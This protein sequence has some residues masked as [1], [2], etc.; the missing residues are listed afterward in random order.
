[1]QEHHPVAP[2]PQRLR[3]WQP[4]EAETH[5]PI[6]ERAR[7]L[8]G[9]RDRHRP[10]GKCEG[11]EAARLRPRRLALAASNATVSVRSISRGK[12]RLDVVERDR[13]CEQD[14]ALGRCSGKLGHGEERLARERGG[15][16]DIRPAAVDQQERAAGSAIPGDTVGIG[17]REEDADG[18]RQ[19]LP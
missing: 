7:G 6:R 19:S 12:S 8:R 1:M 14:A 9:R 13:G 11:T 4:V 15:G 10:L 18:W 16:I 2:L 5:D 3:P 17:E